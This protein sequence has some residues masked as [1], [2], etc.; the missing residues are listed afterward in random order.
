MK[1]DKHGGADDTDIM[2]EDG[3]PGRRTSLVFKV[4]G[5]TLFVSS[6]LEIVLA[7]YG[8]PIFMC[9]F[10]WFDIAFMFLGPGTGVLLALLP[11]VPYGSSGNP[12]KEQ[13]H[14]IARGFL[15]A[16]ISFLFFAAPVAF[17]LVV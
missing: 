15:V 16:A 3:T 2:S 5:T 8:I 17:S 10:G 6:M 13:E 11:W 4:V 9:I 1:L 14:T 12:D 7:S